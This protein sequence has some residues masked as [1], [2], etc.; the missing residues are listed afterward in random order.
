M[1]VRFSAARAARGNLTVR[2]AAL[3]RAVRVVVTFH[4]LP[5]T[6]TATVTVRRQRLA[7]A[8]AQRAVPSATAPPLPARTV[9]RGTRSAAEPTRSERAP[10]VVGAG[11]EPPPGVVGGRAAARAGV[12]RRSGRRRGRSCRPRRGSVGVLGTGR[13]LGIGVGRVGRRGRRQQRDGHLAGVRALAPQRHVGAD[14][15][16]GRAVAVDVADAGDDAAEAVAGLLA[17]EP[18]CVGGI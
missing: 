17:V 3:P 10:V 12:R 11:L 16:V 5:P 7:P 8:R 2:R 13:V 6:F 15:E 4:C 1:A 14:R 18:R 9:P